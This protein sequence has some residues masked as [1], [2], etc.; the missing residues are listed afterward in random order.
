[1]HCAACQSRMDLVDFVSPVPAWPLSWMKGWQCRHCG[2]SVNPLAA[3]NRRFGEAEML[4]A[5]SMSSWAAA[6]K[7]VRRDGRDG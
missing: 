4:G 7:V 1:M 6:G 2:D 5:V 3:I